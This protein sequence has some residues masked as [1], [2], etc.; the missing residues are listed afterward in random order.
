MLARGKEGALV[1][2]IAEVLLG[3][4]ELAL[5]QGD[6]AVQ[7]L[8][9]GPVRLLLPGGRLGLGQLGLGLFEVGF[10]HADLVLERGDLL[11]LDQDFVRKLLV[12]GFGLVGALDRCRE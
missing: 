2:G 4:V 7:V 8:V 5:E 12:L 6:L 10:E 9:G 3:R 11:V 1:G